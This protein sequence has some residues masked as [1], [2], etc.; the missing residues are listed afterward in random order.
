[1]PCAFAS[2]AAVRGWISPAFDIPSVSSTMTR[3]SASESSRRFTEAAM[4]LPM[5][6][7]SAMSPI[8]I[9]AELGGEDVVIQRERG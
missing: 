3:L 9:E 6:V 4:A 8:R 7:P 2:P 1:M 5:A